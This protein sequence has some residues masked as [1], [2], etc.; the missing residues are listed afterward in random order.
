MG[1]ASTKPLAKNLTSFAPSITRTT[2]Q[3]KTNTP[4]REAAANTRKHTISGKTTVR[5]VQTT[6]QRQTNKLHKTTV[7]TVIASIP[8]T[9]TSHS[10]P[11]S[12]SVKGSVALAFQGNIT[13]CNVHTKFTTFTD[14]YGCSSLQPIRQTSCQGGCNSETVA[15]VSFPF[16]N[17]NCFCCKPKDISA[18]K[19]QTKCRDGELKLFKYLVITECTCERCDSSAYQDK[20]KTIVSILYGSHMGAP[21]ANDRQKPS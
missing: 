13:Q 2:E 14:Q 9:E 21:D 17:I 7:K 20:L 8:T 15:N 11:S 5:L 19:A 1:E 10:P 3:R 4:A 12:T 6:L 18:A 16:L